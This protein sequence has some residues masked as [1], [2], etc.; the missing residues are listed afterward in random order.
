MK[1]IFIS[2]AT[3]FLVVLA[4]AV[5]DEKLPPLNPCTARSIGTGSFYDLSSLSIQRSVDEKNV[6]D[7]QSWHARGYD[8]P[9]N[10]TLNICRPV[11]ERLDDVEGIERSLREKIS[12]FYTLEGKTYS[13]GSV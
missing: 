13:I 9:A 8:Y 7:A 3:L 1:W 2:P 4:S 6:K 11:V 5:D 12:A 10:F